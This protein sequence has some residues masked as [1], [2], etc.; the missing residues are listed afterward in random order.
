VICFDLWALALLAAF[1]F[2]HLL[3]IEKIVFLLISPGV[4]C[5]NQAFQLSVSAELLWLLEPVQV[6]SDAL[7]GEI[8]VRYKMPRQESNLPYHH[9]QGRL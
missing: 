3:R 6:R 1:P 7:L 4:L 8:Q 2:D 9:P 5:R